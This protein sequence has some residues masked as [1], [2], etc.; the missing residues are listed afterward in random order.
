M[1]H[2]LYFASRGL[3][4]LSTVLSDAVL[5]EAGERFGAAFADAAGEVR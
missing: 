5:D 4:V 2:G 3:L 1:N